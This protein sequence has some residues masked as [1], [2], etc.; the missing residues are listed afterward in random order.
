MCIGQKVHLGFSYYFTEKPEGPFCPTQ[1][2]GINLTKCAQDHY[3]ENY[4]T[5]DEITKANKWR[6]VTHSWIERLDSIRMSLL[7][8]LILPI[9]VKKFWQL[10]LWLLTNLL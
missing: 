10:L 3:G 8:N 7:P 5:L 1:N 2:L 4:N 9:L 6:D